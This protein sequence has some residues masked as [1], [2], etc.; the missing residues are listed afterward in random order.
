[1]STYRVTDL[2]PERRRA[3]QQQA[4][5]GDIEWL[6]AQTVAFAAGQHVVIQDDGSRD[7]MPDLRIEYADRPPGFGEVVAQ[8]DPAYGQMWHRTMRAPAMPLPGLDRIWHLT[9][10]VTCDPRELKAG[11]LRTL[12]SLTAKGLTF[13]DHH[14]IDRLY[15]IDDDDV[16]DLVAA[17]VVG[18][19]SRPVRAGEQAEVTLGPEGVSAPLAVDWDLVLDWL[20]HVLASPSLADVRSK[21]AATGADERHAAI[22]VTSSSPGE[23]V[24]ALSR[25]E[26]SLPPRPPTLPE[27]ITHLWLLGSFYDRH[28]A[29]YPEHGW[30]ETRGRLPGLNC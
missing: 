20:D 23:A 29:W 13:D 11:L 26:S 28:L 3:H 17:G 6:A 12:E 15:R 24:F 30:F 1:M 18:I 14:G 7:A 16:A 9:I 2:R 19:Y 10:S 5:A 22:G 21:L 27:E 4:P 25:W 8:M